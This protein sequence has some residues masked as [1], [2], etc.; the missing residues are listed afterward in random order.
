MQEVW[1]TEEI[2]DESILYR[3]VHKTRMDRKNRRI[4]SE[5]NFSI[6]KGEDGLS[7]DWDNYTTPA[8]SLARISRT[9]KYGKEVFKSYKDFYVFSLKSGFVKMI[10]DIRDVSH[11]PIFN[12][13]P[14]PIGN[15]NNRAHSLIKFD[16][17]NDPEVRLKLR[18]HAERITVNESQVEK[19][20]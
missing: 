9:Y 6:K 1:E 5:S 18:D 20:L 4:P 3:F 16:F 2:P 15:P 8:K 17:H 10:P 13:D 19:L 11:D 14:E 12:G 7:V